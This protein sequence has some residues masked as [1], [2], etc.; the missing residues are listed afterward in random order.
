MLDKAPATHAPTVMVSID[1]LKYASEAPKELGLQVRKSSDASGLKELEASIRTHGIIVPLVTKMHKGQLYVTAG[2][3]RLKLVRKIHGSN[4]AL[5]PCVDS[6]KLGGDPREIAMATNLGLPPHPVDRYEVIAQLVKEGMSPADAQAHFGMT[7]RLYAQ[8]MRLGEMAPII[9]D[10]WRAGEI[11]A[12]VVRAFALS[13]D[14]KEQER[15]YRLIK[16]TAYKGHVHAHDVM[17]RIIGK[18]SGVGALVE[19]VGKDECAKAKIVVHEDLFS[20][21]HTVSD[22]GKLKQLADR[23]LSEACDTLTKQ[24]WAWALPKADVSNEWNYSRLDPA[25]EPKSDADQAKLLAEYDT[26]LAVL[27]DP[28]AEQD[29]H[30]DYSLIESMRDNLREEIV[31]SGYT[32]AQRKK[33]GCLLSLTTNGKLRIEYGRI[34][35]EDKKKVEASERK[36]AA[37]ASDGKKKGPQTDVKSAALAYRLSTQLTAAAGAALVREPALAI[38]ALI[39]GFAS[40]DSVVGVHISGDTSKPADFE[41]TFDGNIA[42]SSAN[43]EMLLAQICARALNFVSHNPEKSPFKNAA[44]AAIC[45]AISPQRM[46]LELQAAFDAKDY[47]ESTDKASIAKAVREAMGPEHAAKVEKMKSAE[48]AKFATAN[49][50]GTGW[51]PPWLRT[52]HY[53]GPNKSKAPAR[54]GIA[55]GS[56]AAKA[57]HKL[58]PKKKAA[59]KRK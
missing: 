40:R 49:V 33:A 38:S 42:G 43:R 39:A 2:N 48:A 23:K 26:K 30:V 12:G 6:D 14:P 54:Q 18:Q 22:A 44:V 41:K 25:K 8:V 29:P 50:P 46:R 27:D 7:P 52:V 4:A 5:V 24:G 35:P 58:H 21:N 56:A 47:F 45:N 11:D 28:E 36:A 31:A 15:I 17:A 16:K 55:K 13:D 3:R 19:F 37:P 51:L 57:I 9:R 32:E 10:A 20:A 34:K 59:K 53:E 1:Q